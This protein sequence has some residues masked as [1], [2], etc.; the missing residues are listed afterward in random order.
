MNLQIF[1]DTNAYGILECAIA[2][3]YDDNFTQCRQ[4]KVSN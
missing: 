2:M 1:S 3:I 4:F